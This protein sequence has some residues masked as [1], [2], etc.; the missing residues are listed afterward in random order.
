M[1]PTGEDLR[2][3]VST[4]GE[5]PCLE[6][7]SPECPYSGGAMPHREPPPRLCSKNSC[8]IEASATL[9][10]VYADQEAV[11]G[12]L[13]ATKEPHTYD[14]CQVHSERLTAPVGWSVVRYR[15]YPEVP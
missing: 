9:T 11:I 2:H 14:L 12:P 4:L 13:A 1:D 3:G 10:Y 5:K 6:S 7:N 15:P 8:H